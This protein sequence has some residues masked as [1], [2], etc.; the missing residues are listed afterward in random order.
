MANDTL[1]KQDKLKRAFIKEFAQTLNFTATC[2]NLGVVHDTIQ[3]LLKADSD[4]REAKSLCENR[5]LDNIESRVY[6][7]AEK[8]D[9]KLA[10]F[11][12]RAR[13]P[14]KYG[15]VSGMNQSVNVAVQVN[16]SE[17]EPV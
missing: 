7:D 11:L 6:A 17:A 1:A 5:I 16:L 15:L 14:E 13:R 2:E 3:K 9:N 12:L 8:D 10:M 4:F